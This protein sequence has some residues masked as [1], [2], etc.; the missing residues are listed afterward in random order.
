MLPILFVAVNGQVGLGN[1]QPSVKVRANAASVASDTRPVTGEE[2]NEVFND[3][4]G[5]L[6]RHFKMSFP[7]STIPKS[8]N[9]MTREQA[10]AEMSAIVA[11]LQPQV[12]FTLAPAK[13]SAKVFK[14]DAGQET[15]LETLVKQGY[16]GRV[17]PLATGP[18]DTMSLRE[19][20][21]ALGYFLARVAEMT[22]KTS[23]KWSPNLGSGGPE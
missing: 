16:V 15:H 14:I 23:E 9:P 12:Q 1:Q 20:G 18:S 10:V 6:S 13:Y 4:R 22:H 21:S 11:S 19:F 3:A 7:P 5:V 8:P 17:A 2:A